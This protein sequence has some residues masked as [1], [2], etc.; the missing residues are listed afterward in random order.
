MTSSQQ[1]TSMTELRAEIDRIDEG[2][3]KLLAQRAEMIDRAIEIKGANGIP[4]RITERVEEVVTL[5][6]KQAIDKGFDPDF[7]ET[8]WRQ[9]IDWSITREERV[10]GSS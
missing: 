4:A 6:R 10:L 2:L 3:I 5:V 8:L 7:A 1:I 9:L